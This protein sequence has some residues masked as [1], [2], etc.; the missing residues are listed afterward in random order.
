MGR[1]ARWLRLMGID[2]PI[3]RQAPPRLPPGEAFLTRTRRLAHRPGFVLVASERTPEQLAQVAAEL[4][5]TLE[6]EL[7]FSRCLDCNRP[8]EP[9]S[10]EQAAGSVPEFTLQHAA[11]FTRCPQCGRVFWPGSHGPRALAMLELALG[12]GGGDTPPK[13]G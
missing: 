2:A 4:G 7:L 1:L 6:P 8:V 10:R 9:I 3:A 11:S 13:A 12:S 5:L